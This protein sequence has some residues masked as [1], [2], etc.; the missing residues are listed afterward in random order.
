MSYLWGH[1]TRAGGWEGCGGEGGRE[2]ER[3]EEK[4]CV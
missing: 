3:R 1:V 2:R 4:D